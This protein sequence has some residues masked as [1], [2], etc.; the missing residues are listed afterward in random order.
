[1]DEQLRIIPIHRSLVRPQLLMG[2][3]RFL[4][5]MLC[6]VVTL[7][8][9][10]GG[11]VSGNYFNMLLAGALFFGGRALLTHMAKVDPN[12]SDVFR[13]NVRYLS[14]YPALSTVGYRQTPNPKR[15]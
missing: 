10:P 5:L 15:W 6:M 12:M 13:R 7:L 11:I 9:G 2:C 8:A 3:E 1:M 14:E 4:I